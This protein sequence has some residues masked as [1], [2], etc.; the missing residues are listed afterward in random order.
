MF[1]ISP[2]LRKHA[3]NER[4]C[5]R[6]LPAKVPGMLIPEMKNIT[7]WRKVFQE[8][9]MV[10]LETKFGWPACIPWVLLAY[11]IDRCKI[12]LSV[13]HLAW[14]PTPFKGDRVPLQGQQ[15]ALWAPCST[16]GCMDIC[17]RDRHLLSV[18][19]SLS[20]LRPLGHGW[21]RQGQRRHGIPQPYLCSASLNQLSRLWTYY[22]RTDKSFIKSY[23]GLVYLCYCV[24]WN[25]DN[26]F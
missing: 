24:P 6:I 4:E 1:F 11:P 19:C 21:W 25:L 26:S 10:F 12:C 16:S 8:S 22:T 7:H 14:T 3:V 15:P 18:I 20:T 9:F 17:E 13:V 2:W 5:S 23:F